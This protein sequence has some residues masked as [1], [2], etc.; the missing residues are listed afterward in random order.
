MTSIAIV[1]PGY[2]H[3]PGGVRDH[4]ERLRDHWRESGI[5]IEVVG[6]LDTDPRALAARWSARGVGAALI[7][8]VPFLY[9]PRGVSTYPERLARS[10][11]SHG[12]RV[13]VFVHEP[14]VPLTRLPWLVLGPLQRVQLRRLAAQSATVVTAVP[15]W[16]AMLGEQTELV[17]VGSNLGEVPPGAERAPSLPSPVVFSVTAAGLNLEWIVGAERAIGASPGLILVGTDAAEARGHATIGRWFDPSWD[18]RG[19]L[20][21][22]EVL[23]ALARAPLVL[24][25]FVDGATGRRGSLLAALSAGARVISSRGP[26]MDPV[27]EQSPVTLA[28]SREQFVTAARRSWAAADSP[29]ERARRRAWY[30]LHFDARALDERLLR[31]V[32]GTGR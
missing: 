2:P 26:L 12:I 16:Q 15:A 11:R 4:T 8:Y 29:A 32:L 1:C 24:A 31:I 30:H 9:G 23:R 5:A 22:P 20:P 19:R 21:A 10:A 17:Y 25:P 3:R 18:Y 27:F 28:G 6:D 13:I 14:W 7:E